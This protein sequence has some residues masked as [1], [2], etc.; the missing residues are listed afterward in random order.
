M[1]LRTQQKFLGHIRFIA[2]NFE[3]MGGSLHGVLPQIHCPVADAA[4]QRRKIEVWI[5]EGEDFGMPVRR[6]QPE[7]ETVGENV[8]RYE[9]AVGA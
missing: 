1:E 3:E 6:L 9:Q 8:V 2:K 5:V 4:G 7:M